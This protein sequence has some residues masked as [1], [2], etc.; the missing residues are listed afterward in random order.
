MPAPS[1]L[2]V[3]DKERRGRQRPLESKGAVA[4]KAKAKP[5]D[6]SDSVVG[7]VDDAVEGELSASSDAGVVGDAMGAAR[8]DEDV[9]AEAPIAAAVAAPAPPRAKLPTH[10]LG[11]AV[12]AVEG[13]FDLRHFYYDR[14]SVAC[15]N[16]LHT[17]CAKSRSVHMDRAEFGDMG[18]IYYLGA[19]LRKC[20]VSD[21]EHKAFRPKPEDLAAF[22]AEFEA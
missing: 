15:P 10:I 9:V 18:V 22:Q 20:E 12:R 3:K 5:A 21:A 6:D 11:Q 13:R 1:R 17:K 4:V 7:D 8:V 2:E 19:W 14:L 16:P